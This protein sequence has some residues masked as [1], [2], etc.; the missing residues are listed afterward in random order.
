MSTSSMPAGAVK[1]SCRV[2]WAAARMRQSTGA[3]STERW[4]AERFRWSRSRARAA[5]AEA[6]RWRDRPVLADALGAGIV[7]AE[8]A[9]AVGESLE[10]IDRVPGV[11]ALVTNCGIDRVRAS[12]LHPYGAR[13]H[14]AWLH[15]SAGVGT[16]PYSPLRLGCRPEAT[17]LTLTAPGEGPDVR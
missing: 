15:V 5:V 14:S 13:G 6:G 16:G 9:T 4:L 10:R 1:T 7:T 12:G 11:G 8:Q 2:S 17:L 3:P